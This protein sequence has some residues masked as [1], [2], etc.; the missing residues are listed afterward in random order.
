MELP[1]PRLPKHLRV[2]RPRDSRGEPRGDGEPRDEPR[3]QLSIT[4]P[5]MVAWASDRVNVAEVRRRL[6]LAHNCQETMAVKKI[7]ITRR[8]SPHVD[9]EKI[10]ASILEPRKCYVVAAYRPS[11]E[12]PRDHAVIDAVEANVMRF[13]THQRVT[14]ERA[15]VVDEWLAARR[16]AVTAKDVMED[17]FDDGQWWRHDDPDFDY[18]FAELRVAAKL[19]HI[20]EDLATGRRFAIDVFGWG[21]DRHDG[22]H[23]QVMDVLSSSWEI[24]QAPPPAPSLARFGMDR[25]ESIR[26]GWER[27]VAAEAAAM[28]IQRAWRRARAD[29]AHPICRKRLRA[30]FESLVG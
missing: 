15:A 11:R 7:C 22:V 24:M 18:M 4:L 28:V 14:P 9:I 1:W 20:F 26:R 17:G 27:H 25:M 10:E 29:P 30:E 13:I 2:D 12:D 8:W 5:R 16:V 3:V 23:I 21:I 19:L 6:E